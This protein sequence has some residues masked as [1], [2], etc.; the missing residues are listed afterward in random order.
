MVVYNIYFWR[1]SVF[2]YF[3]LSL[4]IVRGERKK[5]LHTHVFACWRIHP[6]TLGGKK[7]TGE[8]LSLQSK[9]THAIP[10]CYTQRRI[11]THNSYKYVQI[12]KMKH[13]IGLSIKLLICS[14]EISFKTPL[15]KK[16]N[17]PNCFYTFNTSFWSDDSRL[18]R[19]LNL[20]RNL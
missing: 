1:F 17:N 18:F 20:N 19:N 8:R 6:F 2:C 4:W 9:C 10:V 3:F 16:K 15:T 7:R 14:F 12:F 13:F 5:I 11:H